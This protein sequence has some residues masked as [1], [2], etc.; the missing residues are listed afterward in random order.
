MLPATM[1]ATAVLSRHVGF[2]GASEHDAGVRNPPVVVVGGLSEVFFS[3]MVSLVG[4]P[5]LQRLVWC[6]LLHFLQRDLD[7]H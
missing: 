3:G 5:L 6:F 4:E 7:V 2:R 1:G